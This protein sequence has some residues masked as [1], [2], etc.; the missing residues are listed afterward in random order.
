MPAETVLATRPPSSPCL[1]SPQSCAPH[2]T[3][4]TACVFLNPNPL[5]AAPTHSGALPPRRPAAGCS[6]T[7]PSAM[8]F[9][10][11][12]V[13]DLPD[14]A[15]MALGSALEHMQVRDRQATVRQTRHANNDL[16]CRL[17][18]SC[19]VSPPSP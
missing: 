5:A 13:Q 16:R 11:D 19:W 10:L 18:V 17:V 6:Y 12:S 15:K 7:R 8:N 14:D 3:A 4:T 2:P 9:P 1:L